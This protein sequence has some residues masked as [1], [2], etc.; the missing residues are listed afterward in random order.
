MKKQC[1]CVQG[2]T[3]KTKVYLGCHSIIPVHGHC[4]QNDTIDAVSITILTMPRQD[5]KAC[6]GIMTGC[7]SIWAPISENSPYG[8]KF[9]NCVFCRKVFSYIYSRL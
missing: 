4:T 3:C 6:K 8:Q 1:L 7:Y 5:D 2:S 9:Q